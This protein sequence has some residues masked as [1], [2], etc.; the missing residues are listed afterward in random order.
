MKRLN[1]AVEILQIASLR[2][3]TIITAFTRWSRIQTRLI[4]TAPESMSPSRIFELVGEGNIE[5]AMKLS[6]TYASSV[7]MNPQDFLSKQCSERAYLIYRLSA[8]SRKH[9]LEISQYGQNFPESVLAADLAVRTDLWNDDVQEQYQR[10]MNST[11]LS[12]TS[13]LLGSPN[14]ARDYQISGKSIVWRLLLGRTACVLQTF[15]SRKLQESRVPHEFAIANH[16]KAARL[17]DERLAPAG[18]VGPLEEPDKT[19]DVDVFKKF[20]NDRESAAMEHLRLVTHLTSDVARHILPKS[21]G[22]EFLQA[23]EYIV[24]DEFPDFP[25]VSKYARSVFKSTARAL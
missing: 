8:E 16:R 6:A 18:P 21:E 17:F 9:A 12:R 1:D 2:I 13:I 10:A 3:M 25:D 19:H 4:S 24:V 23:A 5:E 7:K 11:R 22:R 20:A 14:P 15:I